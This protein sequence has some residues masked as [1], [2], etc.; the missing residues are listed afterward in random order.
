MMQGVT[1]FCTSYNMS[2]QKISH[3]THVVEESLL[4]TGA[5]KG[6]CVTVSHSE[7]TSET[8]VIVSTPDPLNRDLLD[9]SRNAIQ[10]AILRGC[11]DNIVV[12]SGSGDGPSRI[13]C[14]LTGQ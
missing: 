13:I 14:R 5:K 11:C 10:T 9:D 3:I 6:V 1:N 8:E 12:E 4:L 2:S 7:K